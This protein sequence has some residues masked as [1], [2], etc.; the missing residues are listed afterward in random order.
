VTRSIRTGRLHALLLVL[1]VGLLVACG[2]PVTPTPV[3]EQPTEAPPAQD[4]TAAPTTAPTAPVTVVSPTAVVPP[5]A[6]LTVAPRPPTAAPT[7]RPVTTS[8]LATQRLVTFYGHPYDNRMGV[9]GEYDPAVVIQKLKEQTAAYTAADPSRPGLCTVELIASVAQGSP[10]KD[11]LYLARTPTAEIE[12]WA[13]LTQQQGCLLLLDIQMGYDSVDNDIKAILPFLQRPH[14]HLAIDPEFH[15]A[16]G[17]IPGESFGS[18]SS[19]EVAGAMKTLQGLVQQYNL[20]DKILV[21]HQFRDDMLP[22][23]ANIKPMANVDL[24][25]MMDGWGL[26][27]A[28]I[29]NYGAFIRDEPIQYGGIKLF[30]KQDDPLLTPAE[31]IQLDPSPLVIIYQ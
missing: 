10:G 1:L 13:Q 12:K 14:V 28:K 11:G 9:L 4:P 18:V 21:L 20:P 7:A 27:Q 16:R 8:A 24:V 26:P 25:V 30:Y 15:V 29:A 22:D 23:K 6:P 2:T 5:T 17:K 31:V 19:T 3:A